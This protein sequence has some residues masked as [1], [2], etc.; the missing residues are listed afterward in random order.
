MRAIGRAMVRRRANAPPVLNRPAEQMLQTSAP[1]M[2]D[3][4]ATCVT[5]CEL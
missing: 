5:D 3:T 1:S 2:R 4:P